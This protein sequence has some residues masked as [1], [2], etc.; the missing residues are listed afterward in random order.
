MKNSTNKVLTIAVVLLLITNIALVAFMVFGK[1]KKIGRRV[2]GK[3]PS[4][5]MAKELGMTEDQ[6][7]QHKLLKEEHFKTQKPYFDSLR[8]AK[9]AFFQL[10]KVPDVNDT[11]INNYYQKVINWQSQIDKLTFA[12]FRKVRTLFKAEQ[13]PKYDEFIQKMMQ[14]GKRDSA[15]KDK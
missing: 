9:T 4:E 3:D 11:T 8:A 13:L 15:R 6:K 12:H 10:T 2:G 5:M 1:G 14:R 7:K